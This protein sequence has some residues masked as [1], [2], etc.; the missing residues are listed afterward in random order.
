M[1]FPKLQSTDFRILAETALLVLLALLRLFLTGDRDILA[2][3]AGH[4][5]FWYVHRAFV[6]VWSGSYDQHSFEHPQLYAVW[7]EA[8]RSF[9]IPARLGVELAWVASALY[10]ARALRRFT[11]VALIGLPVAAFLLFHPYTILIFDR[12]LAETMLLVIV[13]AC[14]GAGLDAWA[15][16]GGGRRWVL[17]VAG[18]SVLFALAYH[19]RKEGIALLAALAALA[20]LTVFARKRW[21]SLRGCASSCGAVMFAWPLVATLALGVALSTANLV[22]WGNFTRFEVGSSGFSRALGDL[23]AIDTGPTPLQITVTGAMLQAGYMASPTLAELKPWLDGPTGKKWAHIG[24][25]CV[26]VPGEIGNGWFYW[27][28]RDAASN[29]GWH[30]SGRLAE[31]KYRAVADE[32]DKAF[33]SGKLKRRSGHLSSFLDPDLH[34]WMPLVPSSF[35]R[36]VR[37]ALWPKPQYLE[38]PQNPAS[39]AQLREYERFGGRLSFAGRFALHGWVIAPPGSKVGVEGGPNAPDWATVSNTLRPDVPGA[40]VID[41]EGR[42]P[43]DAQQLSIRTP[44]GRVGTVPISELKAGSAVKTNGSFESHMGVDSLERSSNFHMRADPLFPRLLVLAHLLVLLFA[45][46]IACGLALVLVRRR[47]SALDA[48]AF[49]CLV[50][51]A[52]R[53]GLF[54][55]L[56]A[57]SW[58]GGQPRY[59]MAVFP[60][61]ACAGMLGVASLLRPAV[62]PLAGAGAI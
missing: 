16:R 56:D 46:G 47:A 61:F 17:A 4:D 34:K 59:L 62:K 11:G 27:A 20:V 22:K 45:A 7:L 26:R 1:R 32:L 58:N 5:E 39:D 21:W 57:S 52:A 40:R 41:F 54:S 49:A 42:V 33:A 55:L 43:E 15:L 12:T 18:F 28:I 8:L 37:I 38:R 9:G 25:C 19:W 10:L 53:L 13:T 48:A 35:A 44:D 30:A 24:R 60:L 2:L 3:N 6:G 23:S 31:S 51:M 14:L 50:F 36:I 29:A